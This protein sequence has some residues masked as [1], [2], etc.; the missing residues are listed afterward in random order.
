MCPINKINAPHY[1]C[2]EENEHLQP[3]FVS[4]IQAGLG[5]GGEGGVGVGG[6]SGG[7]ELVDQ[8]PEPNGQSEEELWGAI[9][10]VLILIF[11]IYL[12]RVGGGRF[13]EVNFHIFQHSS[14]VFGS[15]LY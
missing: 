6:R 10:G 12:F 14:G 8:C 4:G 3:R 7:R 13:F 2:E 9:W 11:Y 1:D 15:N 5:V